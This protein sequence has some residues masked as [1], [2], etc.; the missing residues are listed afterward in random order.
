MPF[1]GGMCLTCHD[2]HGSNIAGMI[3]D[4][5]T[6]VCISCHGDMGKQMMAGAVKHA[7]VTAGDCTKCHSPH[8][9][10]ISKLLLVESPDMC[11]A[12]HKAIKEKV[13]KE[14]AHQPARRDCLRCHKPHVSGLPS[15]MAQPMDKMCGECHDLKGASFSRA[16]IGIDP[17]AMNC[18][19]CH[20]PHAS[21]DPKLFKDII[22]PPFAA[23]SCDE[24][25]VV[26]KQ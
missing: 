20:S 18:M 12:C 16:H 23:R 6:T 4:K 5:Q 21:K 9:S 24:C 17:A 19:H 7:P 13:E 8:K 15:L 1:A 26:E 10:K 2:A 25:H 11:F 14:K 3:V 22:H